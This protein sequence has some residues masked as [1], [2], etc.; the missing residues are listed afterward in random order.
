VCLL[1]AGFDV[2]VVDN[3]VNSNEVSLKRVLEITGAS[4]DR[5]RFYKADI[6]DEKALEH[7]FSTS[8][9]FAACIHFAGLKAVG[10]SVA[11]PLLYYHNNLGSTITLLNLMDKYACR[12]IIFSS[13]ATVSVMFVCGCSS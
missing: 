11:K 9:R 8:P 5:V 1:E 3:L 13:S 12:S 4:P 6:C 7:V 10:E 2:T